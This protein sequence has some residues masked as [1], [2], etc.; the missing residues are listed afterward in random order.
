MLVPLGLGLLQFRD[1]S[2]DKPVRN[3]V[4]YAIDPATGQ[5]ADVWAD[6]AGTILYDNG[7]VP[8]NSNGEAF[9]YGNQI[10]TLQLFDSCNRL[11]QTYSPV[12]FAP[13]LTPG[14][15][16]ILI[17]GGTTIELTADLLQGGQFY[18]FMTIFVQIDDGGVKDDVLFE[19]GDEF[20]EATASGAIIRFVRFNAV[21]GGSGD[22]GFGFS[23]I[24]TAKLTQNQLYLQSCGVVESENTECTLTRYDVDGIF[25]AGDLDF[26]PI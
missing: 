16:Y 8:L 24:E 21:G 11:I 14:M 2:T 6:Q 9:L 19:L 22:S 1:P 5:R 12:G 23:E 17:D 10:Y 25:L 7:E 15:D 4:V 13:I 26:D 20:L 18:N 3:G